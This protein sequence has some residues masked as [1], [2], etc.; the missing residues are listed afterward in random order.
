MLKELLKITFFVIL[1]SLCFIP[2]SASA[3]EQSEISAKSA[4]LMV[5][6]TREL[7]FGK[8]E[9]ERRS[10]A[11]TTKIMTSILALEAGEPDKTVKVTKQMVAV[12]GTSIG[13]QEGDIISLKD[14][15]SGMLLE[16][17]NDAANATACALASFPQEFAEMMNQKA[18][19]IGM[20]KTHFVTPSGLDNENHYSCAYDMALLG[21]YAVLN[22]Q[23]KEISSQISM[24]VSYGTPACTRTFSNHNRLLKSYPGAVGI[25]TGFTK[26]SGRCLVSA[27]EQ[28]G[29]TLVAVTLNAPN[30]WDDH[31]KLLDYGFSKMQNYSLKSD[32]SMKIP[33]VSGTS[34]NIELCPQENSISV[35]TDKNDFREEIYLPRFI[36]APVKA[37]DKVGEIRIKNTDGN[38][39]KTISLLSKNTVELKKCNNTEVNEQKT[40]KERIKLYLEK[41]FTATNADL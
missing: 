35:C 33:I 11:S 21:S 9:Y 28:N 23:F 15:V 29:V 19:E 3:L 14:L 37:G 5:A 25:K 27:A 13:L 12:E 38:E 34:D 40:F 8:N 16:S 26:K 39:I 17:G 41:K 31:K 32:Y 22:P 20:S 24:R 2:V 10:M 36:Y 30:D 7:L 1:I 4:A 18:A 6:D